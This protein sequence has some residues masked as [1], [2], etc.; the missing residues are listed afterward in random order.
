MEELEEIIKCNYNLENYI[1]RFSNNSKFLYHYYLQDPNRLLVNYYAYSKYL[2]FND[3]LTLLYK[4][5]EEV[6]D[7]IIDCLTADIL[8]VST[9]NDDEKINKMLNDLLKLDK[10]NNI[11][12]SN[13]MIQNK[14]YELDPI[15]AVNKNINNMK[16]IDRVDDKDKLIELLEYAKLHN[17]K[18]TYQ[19]DLLIMNSILPNREA[20]IYFINSCDFD[21]VKKTVISYL[22][23][24]PYK[25]L[26]VLFNEISNPVIRR[27]ILEHIN[28]N[29][30]DISSVVSDENI[31]LI[32]DDKEDETLDFLKKAKNYKFKTNIILIMDRVKMD[33]IDQAYLVYGN[34]IRISPIVNQ[35]EKR[36]YDGIWKWPY[37]TVN[38]IKKS[39]KVLDLYASCVKDKRDVDGNI[40]CLSP[41][42]KY[43]AA[44]IMTIKFSRYR[45][46]RVDKNYH[47]SRS[48]YEFMDKMNNKK[49]VCVGFVHLLR[50][51]LYRMDIK[52]TIDWDVHVPSEEDEDIDD[53]FVNHLRMLVHLKD[54]KYKINGIYMSDPTWDEK[55]LL[56]TKIDH[57][58]MSIDELTIVDDDFTLY[59]LNVFD[60]DEVNEKFKIDNAEKLFNRPIPKD[61][62]IKAFLALDHFLDIN[63]KM[64]KDNKYSDEE[65]EEMRKK[66]GFKE[67]IK[68]K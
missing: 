52:D 1:R 22:H 51:L 13:L 24:M 35:E 59:N 66:L 20:L 53:E 10:K 8:C 57:M 34:K 16:T 40:K 49:I 31:Y 41:L 29:N 67:K 21:G 17:Y 32:T 2:S 25:A 46:E 61:K 9:D 64:V 63:L 12:V 15:Y 50:E 62:I 48:I 37:Y 47:T 26:H 65:Y 4:I 42:E 60:L 55:G 27:D 38:S 43:I 58:L 44:Y 28:F 18:F 14:V 11:N 36:D 39:E 30:F 6:D 5:I 68:K 23:K 56:S 19:N 7:N 3:K 54:D 33:F 45:E